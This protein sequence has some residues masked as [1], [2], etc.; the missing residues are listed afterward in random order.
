MKTL[1]ILKKDQ[2]SKE[3]GKHNEIST[4]DLKKDVFDKVKMNLLIKLQL[5]K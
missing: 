3:K 1:A 4:N 2:K 5:S